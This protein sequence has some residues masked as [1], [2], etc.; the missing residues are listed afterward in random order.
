MLSAAMDPTG[1]A[2]DFTMPLT[3][4]RGLSLADLRGKWVLLEFFATWCAPCMDEM[5]N[6]LAR[7]RAHRKYGLEVFFVSLDVAR[8]RK[9]LDAWMMHNSIDY[10]VGFDGR[11]GQ[12]DVS[13]LYRVES[14]P[15]NH[16][17]DPYGNLVV[18]GLYAESLARVLEAVFAPDARERSVA[19]RS[20]AARRAMAIAQ[21]R[22]SWVV[23]VEIALVA[24]L[25]VLWGLA[26]AQDRRRAGLI[27]IDCGPT[28]RNRR[29][30]ALSIL[31]A[32]TAIFLA[33]IA[34]GLEWR[35]DSRGAVNVPRMAAIVAI[36]L[37]LAGLLGYRGSCGVRVCEGGLL[38]AGDLLSWDAIA[39]YRWE[40]GPPLV[41]TVVPKGTLASWRRC[42]L[43]VPVEARPAMEEALARHAPDAAAIR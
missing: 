7:S 30:V 36:G 33:L 4:G 10:P 12:G 18:S 27:V 37:G 41:L 8:T 14:I 2:P 21:G 43:P 29:L 42:R 19:E 5:P 38:Y 6:L 23:D 32:T 11:G 20:D 34:V 17:V 28:P 25:L 15:S 31:A 16:L 39:S 9:T 26:I 40:N 3:S 1:K 22:P 13:R 24:M 35:P